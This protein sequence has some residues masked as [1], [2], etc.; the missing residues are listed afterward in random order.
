[1]RL[2]K[3]RI[4]IGLS[5]NAVEPLLAFWQGEAG[6]RFDHVL[7]IRRGQDQ[8]RHDVLGSVLKINAHQAP[9]PA[10]PP[11]GY[12]ELLIAREGLGA[13]QA[14]AD[15][16]GNRVSLVPPG[17]EGVTQIGVRIAVRDLA[18][19]RRFYGEAL[20][21]PEE[22][23]GA[24]RAGESLILLEESPDAPSDAQMQGPGWRYITF[25][26]FKVDEEHAGVLAKGGR[27]AL[28]PVTL[29]TTARISMVRDPDGNWIEL[30]QRA[31]IVG[32]LE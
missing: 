31:S 8:H 4:D 12:R 1:M 22:R 15:P 7:P 26:V 17:H 24:F 9:L 14:L 10:N 6:A 32:S 11:S 18:A 19:H 20:G 2:A 3:P 27:E 25:Q 28:A 21:L 23:P 5:T 13:P 29:G 16:E 30:S